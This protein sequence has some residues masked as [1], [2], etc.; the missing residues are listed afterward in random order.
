MLARIFDGLPF[1][2]MAPD[3]RHTYGRAGLIVPG[4]LFLVYLPNGGAL[5]IEQTRKDELP[6][7]YRV[8]D[9]TNGAIL[10]SG[11]GH[12]LIVTPAGAPR[13]VIF[14]DFGNPH[15]WSNQ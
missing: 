15:Q 6:N 13:V 5:Q 10:A 9:P 4:K 11:E 12:D 1:A 2:G 14:A 3:Y 7:Q 8:I